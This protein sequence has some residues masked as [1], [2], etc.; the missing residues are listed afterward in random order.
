MQSDSSLVERRERL[1]LQDGL[2]QLIVENWLGQSLRI[3]FHGVSREADA[4]DLAALFSRIVGSHMPMAI[5]LG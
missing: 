4:R 3:A 5:P 1:V 2:Y